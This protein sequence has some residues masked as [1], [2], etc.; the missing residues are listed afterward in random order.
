VDKINCHT[1]LPPAG[2]SNGWVL[3]RVGISFAFHV[4]EVQPHN[5]AVVKAIQAMYTAGIIR[6]MKGMF[7]PQKK[8]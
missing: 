2:I 8:G 1:V 6:I 4:I 3:K 7:S 5:H